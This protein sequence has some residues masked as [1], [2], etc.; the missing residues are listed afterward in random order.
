MGLKY[1][2]VTSVTRDDLP[3]GGAEQ[4]SLTI[5]ALRERL[6]EAKVE[7]LTP[8]FKG[9]V[10]SVKSVI[11]TSPNVF[12]HNLETVPSLYNKVRP[13]ADYD[14]SLSVLGTASE[15]SGSLL[16]K[17]G[18]MVGLGESFEEVLDV[19]EDLRRANCSMLTIG[20][21]LRPK[22]DSFPVNEYV[23]PDIFERYKEE[24]H[25]MGFRYIASAPLV[26]SS[27]NAEELFLHS[28]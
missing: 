2:V 9:S 21:Y 15:L 12:N 22:K 23:H 20:Q 28:N 5:R 17:S 11:D 10:Q 16:T 14:R 27:M 13:Q 7:V 26:R 8:D 6:P 24:A 18:L 3:D 25:K 19:M 1:V 4:F